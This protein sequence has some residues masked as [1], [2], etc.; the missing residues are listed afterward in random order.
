M[1]GC[2]PG[3]QGEKCVRG[4][5]TYFVFLHMHYKRTCFICLGKAYAVKCII[6]VYILKF[7]MLG[8]TAQSVNKNAVNSVTTNEIAILRRVTVRRVVNVAGKDQ[9]VSSV[10]HMLCI[11]YMKLCKN[12]TDTVLFNPLICIFYVCYSC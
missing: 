5:F 10:R 3:F 11:S 2:D 4:T 7:V 12:H 1:E 8:F 6:T 9:N